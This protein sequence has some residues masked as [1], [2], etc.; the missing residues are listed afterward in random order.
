M[1]TKAV[2][3]EPVTVY[4]SKSFLAA[5]NRLVNRRGLCTDM[6]SDCGTTFV[7][8]NAELSKLFSAQ[9]EY[10]P[11]IVRDLSDKGVQWHFNPPAAPHFG[12]IWE[13]AVK[14]M[15]FHLK[16]VIGE[17]TLTF[18]ELATLLT[19]IEA[20]LNSRPIAALSDDADDFS[21]PTPA[22]LVIGKRLICVPEPS[23][24]EEAPSALSRWNRLKQMRDIF[25]EHWRKAY[26]QSLQDRTKWTC[27]Q[28]NL[29][30]NDLVFV[31]TENVPPAR[32]PLGRVMD[33][34][35]GKDEKVR[36]ATIKTSTSELQRPIVKLVK[37]PEKG[38]E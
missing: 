35:P 31:K 2:H 30:I 5:F 14:S 36:V 27:P 20:C 18:E 22:H 6:Y 38:Q 12:G 23:L 37:I 21:A 15:K 25:W 19:G 28:E 24:I 7:G 8:A 17:S 4:D 34:H 13:S 11:P 10:W 1:S 26:L 29:K 32:W 16:R 3:L 33:V 9:S